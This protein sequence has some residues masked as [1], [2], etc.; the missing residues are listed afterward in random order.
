MIGVGSLEM[1]ASFFHV[2]LGVTEDFSGCPGR[3][4]SEVDDV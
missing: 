2:L 1:L 4:S 3:V